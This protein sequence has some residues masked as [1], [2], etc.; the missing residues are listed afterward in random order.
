V[1]GLQL[2]PRDDRGGVVSAERAELLAAPRSRGG[3][4]VTLVDLLDRLLQ[5]GVVIQGQVVLSA[6]DIDLV[7][8]DL[9]LV[10]AAVDKLAGR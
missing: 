9:S 5:G 10:V 8:V 7:E 6:A 1:A 3:P 4:E 2:R